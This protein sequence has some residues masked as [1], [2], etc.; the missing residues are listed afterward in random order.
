MDSLY[1]AVNKLSIIVPCFNEIENIEILDN[2]LLPIIEKIIDEGG[3]RNGIGID[4][5]EIIF[6]DDGSLDGTYKKLKEVFSNKKL[7]KIEI[8]ILKHKKNLG[9]GAA[10]RTGFNIAEGDLIVT[11]DSDGTYKF[12]GIHAILSC[13]EPG[14]DI[15]TASPYHP[16]GKV[17]GIPAYRLILSRGSS[18]IYRLLMDWRIHT[19]T[20]L[21]RVYRSRVVK[22]VNF[23]ANGFLGGT[24]LLVKA[25][26]KGYVATEIPEELHRR[27]YGESKARI[28][29]TILSH[30]RFQVWLLQ[31]KIRMILLGKDK[32]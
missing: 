25:M 32:Y 21:F 1:K 11:L 13:M 10:L 28:I 8:K 9:L 12:S 15:V 17:V 19:Y 16:L 3:I 31:Q 24:E 6:I 4:F 27:Q 30:L 26:L 2:E 14:I 22:D 23:E 5:A 29:K 18:L 7:P 20:C